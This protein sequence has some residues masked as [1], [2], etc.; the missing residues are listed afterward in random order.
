[1]DGVERDGSGERGDHPGDLEADGDVPPARR[2]LMI[3][4]GWLFFALGVLGV[5]LPVVPT[6]PFMLL[7]LWAFSVGS[8]KFHDW[9]YHHRLFGPPLRR[10]RRERVIPLPVK[11]VA[12]GSMLASFL[13]LWLGTDAPPYALTGAGAVLA[14]SA[15]VLLRFPSRVSQADPR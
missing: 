14:G 12:G 15:W 11:L 4:L 8:R 2:W 5:V 1:M 9:L 3:T 13:W 10:W 6:T 7:A